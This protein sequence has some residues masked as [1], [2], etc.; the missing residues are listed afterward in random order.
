MSHI[1][2]IELEVKDLGIL[3]EAC[4]RLGFSLIRGKTT[5]KWYGNEKEARCDHVINVPGADYE[6]GVIA[7]AGG[8]YELA[9]D[10]FDRALTKIIGQNA[11]RLKQAY[12]AQKA[13]VEARRKGYTAREQKTSTGI[14]VSV[15]VP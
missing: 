1:S 10:Y 8:R 4:K 13:V 5:F 7:K 15:R 14:R 12:A 11:G 9:C 2:T 6:I 3:G